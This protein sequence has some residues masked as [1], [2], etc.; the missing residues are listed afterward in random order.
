MK[1]SR[2]RNDQSSSLRK[3]VENL[4]SVLMRIASLFFESNRPNT[5]IHQG[6]REETVTYN[7]TCACSTSQHRLLRNAT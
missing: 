7:E 3:F 2:L 4:N 6:D 5:Q 1:M